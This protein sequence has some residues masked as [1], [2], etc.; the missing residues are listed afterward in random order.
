MA[1]TVFVLPMTSVVVLVKRWGGRSDGRWGRDGGHGAIG[2][3]EVVNA[4]GGVVV[5]R[6]SCCRQWLVVA[7]EVVVVEGWR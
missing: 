5:S 4:C 6:D 2:G 7:E 1:T 3:V